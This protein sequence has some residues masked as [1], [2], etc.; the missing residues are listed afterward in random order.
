MR[1]SLYVKFDPLVAGGQNSAHKSPHFPRGVRLPN[2]PRLTYIV[3]TTLVYKYF[4]CTC[5]VCVCVCVK[6]VT[7]DCCLCVYVLQ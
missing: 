6:T 1:E 4:L 2:L 7:L 3:H 5:S